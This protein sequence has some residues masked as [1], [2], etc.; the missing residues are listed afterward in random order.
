MRLFRRESWACLIAGCL[1]MISPFAHA[2]DLKAWEDS[3]NPQ[4]HERYIP[5]EPLG[6]GRVGRLQG[7]KNAQGRWHLSKS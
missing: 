1:V 4:T 6:R 5:V 7:I 3:I 2:L